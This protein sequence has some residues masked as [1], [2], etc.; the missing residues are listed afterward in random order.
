MYYRILFS[1]SGLIHDYFD[2][3]S[4]DIIVLMM[5]STAPEASERARSTLCP[6]CGSS[7]VRRSS[8]QNAW[9]RLL[10]LVALPFRCNPCDTRF[11]RIR[12]LG[13]RIVVE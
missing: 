10:S 1:F 5:A 11:F 3:K 2:N 9:E 6:S 8:R 4:I 13:I 7:D 12:L